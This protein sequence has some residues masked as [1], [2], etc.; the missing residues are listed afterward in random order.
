M[1]AVVGPG[2]T[3]A[4]YRVESLLG[5]GGMGVVYR[6]TDLSLQRPVAL[7]L[8]APELA[9]DERFRRRFLKEP[10]LAASLDHPSVIPIYEAGERDGQLYLAMRYV[11]G[12][13]LKTVLER[14]RTLPPERAL[15]ILTQIAGALDA[16]HRR[17]LVHRD[18]KPANILL[19]EDEHAYLTD[20]GITKQGG[21]ASTDT[22]EA[23]GTLD[24][25]AP[26][27]IRGEPVDARSDEYALACVLYECLAGAPPFRRQ[28]QA[29][30]L[31]AHL[32][33]EP[34]PLPGYPALDPVLCKALAKEK[35]DRYPSCDEL[36]RVARARL[37]LVAPAAQ[38][39]A[40][41]LLLRR[42]R[43]ILTAGLL[44][45]VLAIAI[46]GAIVTVTPGHEASGR[47]PIG[48]GVAAIDPAGRRIASFIEA[49]TAPS[50]IAVGQGAVWVLNTE[51]DTV[52][53]ID[54]ETKAVTGRFR[55]RRVATDIAAG[56]GALWL[57]NGG[58]EGGNYTVSISRVDPRTGAVTHTVK[59]PDRT[60]SLAIATFNWGRPDIVVAAGAVWARNPDHTVSR[61]DPETGKLVA[62]IDVEASSIAAGDEGVWVVNGSA[63]T[64]IDPRTNRVGRTI[65]LAGEDPSGI[66][67]GAGK[68]WVPVERDG[69]VWQ[70]EPGPVPVKRSIAVGV[71][72]D[73]IAFGAGAV[74]AGNYIDET[75]SRIDPRTNEVTRVPVGA[76]QALAAGAGGAWVSTA[77]RPPAGTLPGAVC[78]DL[79]SGDRKPDV[80]IASDLPLQG[81]HGAGPRAM[82]D[83]IR[84]ALEQRDFK[85]GRY[86]V[87]YRSCDESTAQTG[88]F[89]NRR[90]AANAEAYA[91]ADDLVAVIG[92]WSS[93]CAQVE[94]PILN[95]A[96]GGPLA[97]IS[98]V[99]TSPGLTRPGQPPPDG[100]RGEPEVYYPTG[101]RNYVRLL[102]GDDLQGAAL[103]VLA[104]RLA[105]DRVYLLHDSSFWKGLLTDPFGR[106]AA[107][108]GVG[109][110]GSAAFD[111]RTKS[112]HVLADTIARSG[113]DGVVVGGDPSYGGD[114]L[115]KALRARLGTRVTIMGGFFFTP[116]LVLQRIGRAG[117]GMYVTTNDLPRGILPLS[118]AGRRFKRDI[119]DPATQYVGVMEAGQA[120]D[121]VMDAIA[122]SDGTR[123]SVLDKLFASD[124]KDGILGNFRFDPNGD[125]TTASIPILRVT[126]ATPPG[127]SIP[128]D[129]QGATLDR[130]VQVPPSLVK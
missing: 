83:A 84:L 74:W 98:P 50:N 78:G 8:I 2:S 47:P 58:G 112:Y 59:L 56:A 69:V 49:A 19:D 70:I 110:A 113:A 10:R 87:G 65:R 27:Q 60:R 17:G 108:L 95:R 42:R 3:F 96:P 7:K 104:K 21:G 33:D 71:G 82:A 9:D 88:G 11:H 115:V 35:D 93:Y 90:C 18:V 55:R 66:A 99:N 92:P 4:G 119:G 38:W 80:L 130:V 41:G 54:P 121:L 39:R 13:D 31:W 103:A 68:V 102:P 85:A 117:H 116:R 12:S 89:E 129:F 79:V 28:T 20:F 73:Y 128:R 36:T 91:G 101:V 106:A 22:G 125:I 5:R 67:V 114:R 81:P 25:L 6:A 23:A 1:S 57:G 64:R 105:L 63:V 109:L 24:Y 127:E 72:V 107:R 16:A 75:V 126:G 52:S 120:A 26:E 62:T 76:V 43:A 53:R 51:S 30:S 15:R 37:G 40:P 29:E 32:Q 97:M 100:E 61:I 124:V 118:A 44:V 46:A 34:A 48:N 122:R 14:E 77:G 123:A 111:P 94:I 86:T 45:L